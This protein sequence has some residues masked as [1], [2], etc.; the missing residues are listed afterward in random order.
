MILAPKE[1]HL[2]SDVKRNG[3]RFNYFKKGILILN[4]TRYSCLTCNIS[5]SGA[6]ITTQEF[7]PYALEIGD[8]C[9][10]SLNAD[11]EASSTEYSSRVTRHTGS[12]IALNF[13]RFIF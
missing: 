1:R 13:L 5:I 2:K 9:S 3:T 7:I 10:L 6:L 4:G 12:E 8:T 11:P